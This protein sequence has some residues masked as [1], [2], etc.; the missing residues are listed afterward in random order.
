MAITNGYCTLD[1]LKWALD[2]ARYSYTADTI[3]FVNSAS[4]ITDTANGLRRWKKDDV[5]RVSGSANN[6]GDFQIDAVPAASAFP[7]E[8]TV[9]PAPTDEAAGDSITLTDITDLDDDV[10]LER[11]I[12][13]VSRAIDDTT[14]R[15]FYAASETRYYTA[16]V[17]NVLLIDD[18]LS[19]TTL[20]TDDDG[21]RTY[22]ETWDTDDYDLAPYNAVLDGAPYTRIETTP[23]GGQRFPGTAKGVEIV[24]SF[25]YSATTPAQI[26]EACILWSER[27]YQRRHAVFGVKGSTV[28][29]EVRL[30]M[31]APDPDVIQMLLPFLKGS[32]L[33]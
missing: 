18:L 22:D 16:R 10:R 7:N 25:G 14:K 28:L 29:G 27:V 13:A 32:A 2:L 20:K 19:V 11:I 30:R 31:P 3:A 15:R 33:I 5:L 21:D 12:E 17:S 4:K 1:D 24:G 6:D 26:R 9:D 23:Q 8:L